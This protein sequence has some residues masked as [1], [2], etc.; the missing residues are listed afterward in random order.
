MDPYLEHRDFFPGLHGD[1]ITYLKEFIQPLLPSHYVAKTNERVWMEVSER[2]I[3]PDVEVLTTRPGPAARLDE[4]AAVAVAQ[5]E[6][7][8]VVIS[9][10]GPDEEFR[11]TFLEIFTGSAG[12][13]RLVTTLEVLSK[14]N[15][16]FASEGWMLYRKKQR[17]MLESQVNLVEIDLLRGGE[18]TTAVPL[19]LLAYRAGA[20]DYHVCVHQFERQWQ[21]SVYPIQL[22]DPLPVISIPLLPGEAPVKVD[23]QQVFGRCYETGAYERLIDYQHREPTPRLRQDQAAWA[24]SLIAKWAAPGPQPPKASG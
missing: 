12:S 24:R 7:L 8:P 21:F 1:M 4:H 15:K 10:E 22:H 23:L 9:L 11:E 2:V 19:K 20:C 13:T 16:A 14:A 18:H 6:Q 17:E 3:E 5:S